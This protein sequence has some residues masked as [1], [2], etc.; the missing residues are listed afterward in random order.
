[1]TLPVSLLAVV[2]ILAACGAG[3]QP[4]VEALP[5]DPAAFLQTTTTPTAPTPTL[6][7][8]GDP[9]ARPPATLRVWFPEPLAPADD[10]TAAEA[11]AE[12]FS[13]FQSA[14][15]DVQIDFR[16][17]STADVGG[18]MA[19]LRSASAVAP[20]ALP[21][22]TLL[23]HSDLVAAAQEGLIEPLEANGLGAALG[24]LHPIVA[25]IGD[26]DGTLYGIPYNLE[27][28]HLA[29]TSQAAALDSWDFAAI[30]DARADFL[31]PAGRTSTL[32][33]TF[34]AQYRAASG[35]LDSDDL[36]LDAAALR[37]VLRFYESA[38]NDSLIDPIVL[39]YVSP[40]DYA[41][42]L[43]AG[44]VRAG[45]VT[46]STYL[47]MRANGADLRYAPIPTEAGD[48][49]TVVDS[50]L[51]VVTTANAERQTLTLRLVDWLL[52]PDRQGAYNA[53][54]H[55]LPSQ[56]RSLRGWQDPAYVAFVDALL[57]RA[58]LP[59]DD[60]ESAVAARVLQSAFASVIAGRRSAQ[61]AAQDV[62]AQLAS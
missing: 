28:Q 15:P 59:L 13:A 36:A 33:E 26:V 47:R 57:N 60:G 4:T 55:M 34:L 16:L 44:S 46:S 14:N 12:Q 1:M 8:T 37:R 6:A 18:I 56:R 24:D 11:L 51:L 41:A 23:R 53:A 38:V 27:I 61:E 10:E 20:S 7:P 54:I 5:A 19:T 43:A 48:G 49:A 45:V 35:T 58:T 42:E 25:R 2:W 3:V 30:L 29:Y 31:F 40:D 32:S 62:M 21:D 9:T 17:K 52:D 50:W 22:L 39:E